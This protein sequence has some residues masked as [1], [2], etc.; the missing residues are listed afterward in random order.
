MPFSP[1]LL[2]LALLT[3]VAGALHARK[4][5][6]RIHLFTGAAFAGVVGVISRLA[7]LGL[8]KGKGPI[9]VVPEREYPVAELVLLCLPAALGWFLI[10]LSMAWGVDA[11]ARRMFGPGPV[12]TASEGQ[13]PF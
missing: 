4:Q 2:V 5:G 8:I 6:S 11:L 1:N 13:G 10:A 3:A 7:Q 9:R 12:G